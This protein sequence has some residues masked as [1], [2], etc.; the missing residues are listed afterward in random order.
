[1][2]NFRQTATPTPNVGERRSL[3]PIEKIATE[4]LSTIFIM[5]RDDIFHDEDLYPVS[6]LDPRQAPLVLCHISSTLRNVARGTPLLWDTVSLHTTDLLSDKKMAAVR[7][8]LGQSG[9]LPLTVD[10]IRVR[11]AP[12]LASERLNTQFLPRIW[13]FLGRIQSLFLDIS[14]QDIDL[15]SSGLPSSSSLVALRSLD[16]RMRG[17]GESGDS[18]TPVLPAFLRF[19]RD[20]PS[21]RT[22]RLAGWLG[23]SAAEHMSHIFTAIFFPWQSLTNFI[24]IVPCT[25]IAARDVLRLCPVLEVCEIAN[26]DELDVHSQPVPCALHHVRSLRLSATG[27]RPFTGF[28]ESFSFPKMLDLTLDPFVAPAHSLVELQHRSQF[29]L[30]RLHISGPRST[31]TELIELLRVLPN[32]EILILS[33]CDASG[34]LYKAFIYHGLVASSSLSLT[35][36]MQLTIEENFFAL[37]WNGLH[38]V[39]NA[40]PIAE[41][42]ASSGTI[43]RP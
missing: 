38:V 37:R 3:S 28:F 21:L 40:A 6:T 27:D 9:N 12:A 20:A 39:D 10:V 11:S 30:K 25:T 33:Q 32:L 34:E 41:M 35:H 24:S 8:L 7:V 14:S 43:S 31:A 17:S 1:M 36:L 26:I 2:V 4:I 16:I 18:A 15:D 22:L 19:F 13:E 5:C 29:Q 23:R 42:A